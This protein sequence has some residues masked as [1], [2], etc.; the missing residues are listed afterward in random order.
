MSSESA[1][2]AIK[3][4]ILKR[5]ETD[6]RMSGAWILVVILAPILEA[7]GLLLCFM[8]SS[9]A[10]LFSMG[11]SLI[12]IGDILIIL[13]IYKLVKRRTE[14]FKRS[15]VL[16]EGLIQYIEWKAKET[17]KTSEVQSH[18]A[19]MR[20]I[21]SELNN[22]EKDKSPG[23]YALLTLLI[24]V[25]GLYVMYFLTKDFGNHDSKERAFYKE[26]TAAMDKLGVSVAFPYWKEVPSRSAG[27][28][29]I[30]TIILGGL[31]QIYWWWVLIK[32]PHNHFEAHAVL[33]DNLLAT[34]TS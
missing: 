30:L 23:L 16:R 18:L 34:I 19:T 8:G 21:H 7:I 31:F 17:E 14:H 4:A 28:Y 26:A 24:P 1:I 22:S 11:L 9:V 32:D 27:L 12:I 33:E 10:E 5:S 15:R 20:M 2:V 25:I 13:L 3:D 6:I 29:I